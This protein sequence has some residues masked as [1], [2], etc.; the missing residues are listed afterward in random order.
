MNWIS[1]NCVAAVILLALS[2]MG[3]ADG[4]SAYLPLNL[5]PEMFT[6]LNMEPTGF[7]RPP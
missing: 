7:V 5:E 3:L 4:V 6:R 2:R 1:R